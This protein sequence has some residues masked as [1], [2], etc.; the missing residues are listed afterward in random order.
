MTYKMKVKI[1]E[2]NTPEGM[3]SGLY[4]ELDC[5]FVHDENTYGNGY[6]LTI[7]GKWFGQNIVD[8]RYDR[9]FDKNHPEKWLEDWAKN[10]WSGKDGAWMI[11]TLEIKKMT[12]RS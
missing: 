7:K 10:Y 1:K 6:W 5:I 4:F 11:D 2:P 12:E 3:V 8:L 9:S